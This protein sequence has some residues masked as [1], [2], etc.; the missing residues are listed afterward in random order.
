MNPYIKLSIK[1]GEKGKD[2]KSNLLPFVLDF[3][4]C[5][6]EIIR[7]FISGGVILD[8]PANKMLQGKI[9]II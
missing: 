6:N 3:E 2:K 5:L 8:R 4:F 7:S 1:E 9:A